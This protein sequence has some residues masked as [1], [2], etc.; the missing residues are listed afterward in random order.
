MRRVKR[1]INRKHPP[2]ELSPEGY[3][4]TWVY[5][6]PSNGL[7][8]GECKYCDLVDIIEDINKSWKDISTVGK[9]EL[10]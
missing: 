2:C 10:I 5:G 1:V 4:H 9:P 8:R 6:R 7:I 3:G